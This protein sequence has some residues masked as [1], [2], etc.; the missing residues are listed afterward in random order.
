MYF[1][2][3]EGLLETTLEGRIILANKTKLKNDNRQKLAKIIINYL[4]SRFNGI[5][6]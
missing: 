2:G 1:K 6:E 5:S 4:M 3:L